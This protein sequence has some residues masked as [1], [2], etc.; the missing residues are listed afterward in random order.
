MEHV[1]P[2]EVRPITLTNLPAGLVG[3][4][5]LRL[6]DSSNNV[7]QAR[8]TADVV[9]FAV[10]NYRKW[11]TFPEEMGYVYVIADD[12]GVEAVEEFKVTGTPDA[13]SEWRPTVAQ[14]GAILR[15]RTYAEGEEGG[16]ETGSEVGTFNHAT[17]PTDAQVEEEIDL[18]VAD[19]TG[20][21]ASE[22]PEFLMLSAQRVTAL[23]AAC[24]VERSYLPEQIEAGQTIY[25]TL[26]L[27]FEEEVKQLQ[28]N[29]QWNTLAAHLQEQAEA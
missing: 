7:I 16:L 25:Q 2:G 8:S 19:V 12:D 26:R 4:L 22:F 1:A 9:E 21:V 3:T 18:A 15:A 24:E 27:T 5:G 23:R 29:A 14:V 10:G 20:R 6:E 17:R 13:P 28:R 11:I